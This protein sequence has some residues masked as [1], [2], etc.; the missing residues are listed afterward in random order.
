[1]QFNTEILEYK[2]YYVNWITAMV[3][4]NIQKENYIVW[5]STVGECLYFSQNYDCHQSL[6]WRDAKISWTP[7]R[8]DQPREGELASWV[9]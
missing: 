2:T 3:L 1:M 9:M 6:F 5:E 4:L 7:A 8:V